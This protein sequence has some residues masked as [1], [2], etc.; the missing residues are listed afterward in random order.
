V[1]SPADE[2]VCPAVCGELGSRML[3]LEVFCEI[4]SGAVSGSGPSQSAYRKAWSRLEDAT[5]EITFDSPVSGLHRLIFERTLG[6]AFRQLS[7]TLEELVGPEQTRDSHHRLL[8]AATNLLNGNTSCAGCQHRSDAVLAILSTET[9][10]TSAC[11]RPLMESFKRSRAWAIDLLTEWGLPEFHATAEEFRIEFLKNDSPSAPLLSVN[12]EQASITV[13]TGVNRF[14]LSDFLQLG[15]AFFHEWSAHVATQLAE[16]AAF[17]DEYCIYWQKEVYLARANPPPREYR[18]IVRLLEA[19]DHH[20]LR[21]PA[22]GADTAVRLKQSISGYLVEHTIILRSAVS[23]VAWEIVGR[24]SI[25]AALLHGSSVVSK[26]VRPLYVCLS[27]P[28]RFEFQRD[29]WNLFDSQ[30][31]ADNDV[32]FP[33]YT[34]LVER[35]TERMC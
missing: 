32:P 33:V 9:T 14:R 21:F 19:F 24:L 18:E 4:L 15:F 34:A 2:N 23:S 29:L 16:P 35:L 20:T 25:A 6:T 11:A 5:S 3:F 7:P 8:A 26:F 10:A 27:G 30:R 22:H 31:I 12:I 17:C 28:E 1:K 13:H